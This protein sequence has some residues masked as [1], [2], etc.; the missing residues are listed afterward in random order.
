MIR[1]E[2]RQFDLNEETW[3]KR[4]KGNNAESQMPNWGPSAL[5][6]GRRRAAEL[7]TS[8]LSHVHSAG[9]VVSSYFLLEIKSC[10]HRPSRVTGPCLPVEKAGYSC[11][12]FYTL[13]WAMWLALNNEILTSMTPTEMWNVPAGIGF[14]GCLSIAMR[15]TSTR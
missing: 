10:V 15:R 13:G 14:L 12:L 9:V 3:E 5:F 8:S 1:N 11:L 7:V 6:C 2:I 4:M